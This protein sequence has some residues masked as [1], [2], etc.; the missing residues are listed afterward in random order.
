MYL[1][2]GHILSDTRINPTTV[3][4]RVEWKWFGSCIIP[5]H[6]YQ[7]TTHH[8]DKPSEPFLHCKFFLRMKHHYCRQ[9]STAFQSYYQ[10][11]YPK[12]EQINAKNLKSSVIVQLEA[13]WHYSDVIMSAIANQI[14]SALIVCSTVCSG[15]DQRKHQSS[16]SLAFVRKIC[17]WPVDSPQKWTVTR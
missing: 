1:S 5:N 8:N 7:F 3:L 12:T 4:P 10:A 15:A 6:N 16:A 11:I 13:L 14:I 17:R 9:K 2:P